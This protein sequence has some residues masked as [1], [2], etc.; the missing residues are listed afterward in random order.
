MPRMSGVLAYA[1]GFSSPRSA[2]T[3]VL[4]AARVEGAHELVLGWTPEP[5]AWLADRDLRGRAILGG[6]ALADAIAAN[7]V[8]YLPVRLSAVPRLLATTLRPDVAVVTGVRRGG[9]LVFASDVG[10][11]PAA[12]RNASRVVVEVDEDGA[13]LGGPPIPGNIVATILR[14][15]PEAP[16][17]MPRPPSAMDLTIARNVVALLP[18]GATVQVGPGGLAD[19][20]IASIS[21]PVRVWS[22]LVTDSVV[23]LHDRGMLDGP[24]TAAY[25]WGGALLARE[26]LVHL[27]PV[28]ETHDITRLSSIEWFAAC[29]TALQV[30]LDGSVNVE[31]VGGRVVAGI[32]GHADFSAGASRS[33]GGLS[34]VALPSTTRTG[35]TTIVPRVECVSTPRADVDIV[36]TEHGVA[37]LR[38][39]DDAER[40]Q[41]IVAIAAPHH[42]PA[43]RAAIQQPE[44]SG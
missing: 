41:R 37:D 38:G 7:R 32:G 5:R 25:T 27:R 33:I 4:R 3:T 28:E 18:E 14:P 12:A 34:I 21:H 42:Q 9:E 17:P 29:N 36:V 2:P 16:P 40:A 44:E 8:Q 10:W 20:V 23:A 30:G 35:M 6:Y 11:G 15:P 26:G 1:D 31:R 13:D 43:L 19:A 22:G 24:A 39:V